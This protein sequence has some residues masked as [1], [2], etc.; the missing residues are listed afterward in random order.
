MLN[1]RHALRRAAVAL[2]SAVALAACSS[3][4]AQQPEAEYADDPAAL[5]GPSGGSQLPP[6][7]GEPEDLPGVN[8]SQLSRRERALWWK[9]SSQLYAPCADQAVSVAQCV[10]ESRP[11]AACAPAT[12]L[13]ADKIHEGAAV[14][15]IQSAYA[16]RF[17]PDVKK[18]D[19]ADSPARGPA[20]APVVIVV[21]SDYECP[22]CGRAV[23]LLDEAVDRNAPHVR[24][25]HKFYPLKSHPH[26]DAAARA[27]FAAKQQGK[28]WEMEHLLFA[29][30]R[31]LEEGDL[32]GYARKLG[33]NL[34]RF[35][36]DAQSEAAEKTIARDRAAA[37]QAGL[38][39]TPFILIN[40]RE[41][42]LAL[43]N[44]QVDLDRWVATEVKLRSQ[45]A[46]VAS[47][48]PAGAAAPGG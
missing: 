25:V 32:L 43:F 28:Y 4:S 17:G 21:W 35:Q 38:S 5:P 26:A 9:M 36:A 42:N 30:Q 24:L 44:L 22:A 11:C 41:F 34:E 3:S 37:D 23:P 15:D 2:L 1:P 47:P 14:S 6:P 12:Q 33:L 20:S 10:R 46:P 45:A 19:L 16:I 27:A 13:I 7:S 18:V 39:G 8:T 48:A 31:A 29:N 40:G